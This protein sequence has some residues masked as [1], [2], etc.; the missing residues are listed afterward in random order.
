MV[1]K[2]GRIC[3]KSWCLLWHRT[4][5]GDS[6][7]HLLGCERLSLAGSTG[8]KEV[9]LAGHPLRG[10][11]E[12][13]LNSH[14]R[15]HRPRALGGER[16]VS[17]G[18]AAPQGVK[19]K[20]LGQLLPCPSPAHGIHTRTTQHP[21]DPLQGISP[22]LL[23][24]E[25]DLFI[26]MRLPSSSPSGLFFFIFGEAQSPSAFP[27]APGP[28]SLFPPHPCTI[29]AVLR[30]SVPARPRCTFPASPQWWCCYLGSS[31]SR[32]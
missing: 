11:H 29:L 7:P 6:C 13:L 16:A 26:C 4:L 30:V 17:R 22:L 28:L 14:G 31:G 25:A 10:H 8:L 12:A 3:P 1:P 27:P 15:S 32:W 9:T 2:P 19:S 24:P 23:N 5:P 18:R 21:H 20:A